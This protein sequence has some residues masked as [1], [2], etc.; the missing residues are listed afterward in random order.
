[1]CESREDATTAS[2]TAPIDRGDRIRG[3]RGTW[4]GDGVTTKALIAERQ[5]ERSL[6]EHRTA[7]WSFDRP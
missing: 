1:M 2:D 5:R 4:S 7:R 6:E 3:L